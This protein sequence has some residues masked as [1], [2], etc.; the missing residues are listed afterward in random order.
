[1]S[2]HP[3]RNW[4]G[5]GKRDSLDGVVART[6]LYEL[7]KIAPV[8]MAKH[9]AHRALER[10]LEPEGRDTSK[11]HRRLLLE[12]QKGLCCWCGALI[13]PG[14]FSVE[15]IIPR[16]LGGKNTWA[17]KAAAHVACNSKRGNDIRQK[18]HVNP[19][20]DFVRIVLR[21]HRR[22]IAATPQV[23]AEYRAAI[24]RASD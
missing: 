13:E 9:E 8:T 18:P 23:L 3:G 21:N 4:F 11:T 15:H 7:Q 14:Q 12:R 20:F 5:S 2:R 19:L 17:N 22:R 24:M 1:M 6:R 16:S 10:V